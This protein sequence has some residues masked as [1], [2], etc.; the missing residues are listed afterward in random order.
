MTSLSAGFAITGSFCTYAKVFPVLEQLSQKFDRVIGIMSPTA[1]Q[2]DTRFGQADTFINRL[3]EISG[4]RI[5]TTIPE[6]EPIGPQ[7][8]LDVLVVAPCTGNTIGKLACGIT[9]T[10]VTMACKSHLRNG[11]PLVLAI[12]TNDGLGA[13]AENIGKLMTRKNVYFVPY[14]Q[15]DPSGKPTSLMANFI[16]LD[17]TVFA[18]LEGRQLQPVLQSPQA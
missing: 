15:D 5:I 18:A 12:A 11:R 7:K 6:A 3:W 14:G 13:S 9:D 17:D 4:S 8:L 1:A 2:T 16:L 10:A